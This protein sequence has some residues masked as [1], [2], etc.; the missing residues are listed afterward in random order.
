MSISMDFLLTDTLNDDLKDLKTEFF[1]SF[2]T[3]DISN[4]KLFMELLSIV[5]EFNYKYDITTSTLEMYFTTSSQIKVILIYKYYQNQKVFHYTFTKNQKT[6]RYFNYIKNKE[7]I[8]KAF[9]EFT[10]KLKAKPFTD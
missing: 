4:I 3:K 9:L 1:E 8:P 2:L 10:N 5:N 6:K 7:D